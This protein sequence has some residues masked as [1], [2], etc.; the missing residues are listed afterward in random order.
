VIANLDLNS[1]VAL[2]VSPV[3]KDAD[4]HGEKGDHEV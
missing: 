3:T 4:A 1:L 2:L